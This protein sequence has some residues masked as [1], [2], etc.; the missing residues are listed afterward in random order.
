M[1]PPPVRPAPR[2]YV[3]VVSPRQS[4]T[5]FQHIGR[6]TQSNVGRGT[7]GMAPGSRARSR[8]HSPLGEPGDHPHGSQRSTASASRATTSRPARSRFATGRAGTSVWST[9]RTGAARATS[10]GSKVDTRVGSPM[11]PAACHSATWPAGA[12][13]RRATSSRESVPPPGPCGARSRGFITHGE[14]SR[15]RPPRVSPSAPA[16]IIAAWYATRRPHPHNTRHHRDEPHERCYLTSPHDRLTAT[17]GAVSPSRVHASAATLLVE[18]RRHHG[19]IPSSRHG[20]AARGAGPR[21]PR[22]VARDRHG[23]RRARRARRRPAR[24]HGQCPRQGHAT[25]S[26]HRRELG[27]HAAD[28]R[29]DRVRRDARH[30]DPPPGS[31]ARRDHPRDGTRRVFLFDGT[32][33]AVFDVDLKAKAVVS[34]QLYRSATIRKRGSN[35][36]GARSPSSGKRK[37][38][39]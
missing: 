32:Q 2:V 15:E 12:A 21:A 25:A 20:G 7:G 29:E 35:G 9:R 16:E 19:T 3:S 23:A 39:A 36:S 28:R 8:R 11:R 27:R 37:A 4:S 30:D 24:C 31:R 17:R 5:V 33:L 22:L 26:H 18:R 10:R 14:A 34:P 6:R 13:A 1:P 38:Y